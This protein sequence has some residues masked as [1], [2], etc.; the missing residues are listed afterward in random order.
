[1]VK[2]PRLYVHWV[3]LL[4][5]WGYLKELMITLGNILIFTWIFSLS[6]SL[7]DFHTHCF[8]LVCGTTLAWLTLAL[9]Q[10]F[11]S[12]VAFLPLFPTMPD[13]PFIPT[14]PGS[15]FIPLIP[16]GPLFP[17]GHSRPLSPLGPGNFLVIPC[18]QFAHFYPRFPGVLAVREHRVFQAF[19]LKLECRENQGRV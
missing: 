8:Q 11:L 2:N 5:D 17:G 15:S 3:V 13:Y 12:F 1:M 18:H 9:S 7:S 16:G 10:S 6:V 4:F 19:H 14:S